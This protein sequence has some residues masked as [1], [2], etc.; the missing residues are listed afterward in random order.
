MNGTT[1]S[2]EDYELPLENTVP[3]VITAPPPGREYTTKELFALAWR[4][5]RINWWR[6]LLMGGVLSG[7]MYLGR[8]FAGGATYDIFDELM[9]GLSRF[10]ANLQW[11]YDEDMG[12][13]LNLVL[14]DTVWFV[15]VA[16]YFWAVVQSYE[17]RTMVWSDLLRPWRSP[18]RRRVFAVAALAAV[19]SRSESLARGQLML[20]LWDYG[21][22]YSL[23]HLLAYCQ[24]ISHFVLWLLTL[25]VWPQVMAEPSV[26]LRTAL[27]RHWLILRARPTQC[28]LLAGLVALA[29]TSCHVV[30]DLFRL[31]WYGLGNSISIGW[32][33]YL[34]YLLM[35]LSLFAVAAFYR[36]VFGLPLDETGEQA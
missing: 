33:H 5:L 34:G 28:A 22:P 27:G 14:W 24:T 8:H 26:N 12:W 35:F 18:W 9:N 10:F 6:A 29:T 32:T 11:L 7:G 3:P 17:R 13:P 31:A 23:V 21:I 15:M 36:M 1:P 19:L 2:P 25:T 30:A 4:R 20:V 16:M